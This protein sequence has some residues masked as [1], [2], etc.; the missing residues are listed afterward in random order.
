[1]FEQAHALILSKQLGHR[2][3]TLE[4]LR[5]ASAATNTA[6]LRRI[7]FA[8]LAL[9]D[10]RLEHEAALDPGVT[11]LQ[12]DPAFARV[13]LASGSGPVTICSFRNLEVLATLPASTNREAYIGFWSADGRFLAI[14]RQ[15]DVVGNRS[16]WEVWNVGQTQRVFTAG[17][18]VAHNSVTFHPQ[19]PLLMIGHGGGRVTE[20]DVEKGRQVRTFKL[21]NTPHALAYSPDGQRLAASYRAG[22]NWVIAF[23]DAANP[24]IVRTVDYPEPIEFAAWH[25]QGRWFSGSAL[26]ASEWARGI[27]LIEPETGI[28]TTLGEHKI[29]TASTQF[30]ADGHYVVSSGWDR[31]IICWDLQTRRRMF[32]HASTGWRNFWSADGRHCAIVQPESALQ[33]YAFEAPQS[34]SLSGNPGDALHGGQFS[35]DGR[36]LVVRDDRHLCVWDV[37]SEAPGATVPISIPPKASAFFS[38]DSQELFVAVPEES[39][40]QQQRG[41]LARWR[42]AA[43]ANANAPPRIEPLPLAFPNGF[44]RAAT[45]SNELVMTSAEGVHFLAL[46]NLASSDGRV[47]RIRGGLGYVSPDGR[48]LAMVYEYSPEVGVYRLPGVEEVARLQTS[49]FVAFITFSPTGDEMLVLNRSGVEWFDTT[50]WQCTRRQPGTPVSGSYACYTPDGKGIWMVTHFRNA[51]LLDRRTLEPIL[52]LPSSV[53]PLALSPNGQQLAVSVDSRYVQLWDMP[54]LRQELAWV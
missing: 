14:K 33:L 10:L 29:K 18:D 42:L 37:N 39:S 32:I 19:R 11:L 49:N 54:A 22:T 3:R 31:D 5:Q 26:N 28:L 41:Y 46:T 6:E 34:R 15:H 30:T 53:L 44:A 35:S 13:A 23:H 4:A 2:T 40:P 24:D 50:T 12:P 27:H 16:D 43:A 36:W 17:P 38:P 21:P 8:A 7:A 20:W 52:P 1:L 25:P 45:T 9:P 47:V 51:A 48:W